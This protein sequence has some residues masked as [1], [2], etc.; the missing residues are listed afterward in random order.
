VIDGQTDGRQH[1]ARSAYMLKIH[2]VVETCRA[3]TEAE[4]WMRIPS[5]NVAVQQTQ[6]TWRWHLFMNSGPRRG[7]RC[8]DRCRVEYTRLMSQNDGWDDVMPQSQQHYR[9]SS[10]V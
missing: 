1:I 9:T 5:L 4:P 7:D 8:Q 6:L 2:S 3:L 10:A